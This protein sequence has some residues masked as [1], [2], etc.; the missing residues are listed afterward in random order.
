MPWE[1]FVEPQADSEVLL[2][3]CHDDWESGGDHYYYCN[4]T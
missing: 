1:S 2:K 4:T 3:F